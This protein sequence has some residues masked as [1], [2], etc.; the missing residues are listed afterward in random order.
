MGVHKPVHPYSKG[1]AVAVWAE[2]KHLLET[3]GE[4]VRS[5]LLCCKPYVHIHVHSEFA[6]ICRRCHL[7]LRFSRMSLLM[8]THVLTWYAQSGAHD[9]AYL[10]STCTNISTANKYFDLFMRHIM[11]AF[12]L[13]TQQVRLYVPRS[14]KNPSY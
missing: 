3:R 7:T 8:T 10:L 12:T 2:Q 4:S 14:Y 6:A 9:P 13:F 5:L 11:T 1:V